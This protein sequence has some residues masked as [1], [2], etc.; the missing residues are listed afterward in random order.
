M[1][2]SII[3][4]PEIAG[5]LAL[6]LSSAAVGLGAEVVLP[7]LPVRVLLQTDAEEA[8]HTARLPLELPFGVGLV[9]VEF[10]VGY[11]TTEAVVPQQFLDALSL[12][13]EPPGT[14]T[15]V[16]LLNAE[17]RGEVWFPN[18]PGGF[19]FDRSILS[20]R[21][22]GFPADLGTEW[23]V[24]SAFAVTL[25][26]PLAWQNCEAGLWLDL[27]DNQDGGDSMAFLRDV[28]LVARAPFF[29]LESSTAPAGPYAAEMGVRHDEASRR[30]QLLRGGVARFFRL[31][32]DSP[33]SLQVL[34]RNSGAWQL[35]YEFPEPEPRLESAGRPTGPYVV[36]PLAVLDAAR[37]EF[38]L[39][40]NGPARFYRVRA[41]VRTALT[42]MT[43]RGGE[44]GITLAFEYRPQVFGLQS[45]AQPCGPFA[46]DPEA[47]FDTARQVITVSRTNFVRF[48]R[49]A[50]ST[51]GAGAREAVRF[52]GIRD[53]GRFWEL[54]YA[55]GSGAEPGK[56]EES[57]STKEEAR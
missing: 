55:V 41:Q 3:H 23:R 51:G 11:A 24:S 30:F 4:F 42:R 15:A 14:D 50:H 37:R 48:F 7:P 39:K 29:L 17:T 53:D 5:L 9:R 27:F 18:D 25:T 44:G 38:H 22:L 12:S 34:S 8:L 52:A 56:S 40:P 46:D 57:T 10:T 16:W 49:V 26:L 31:R 13:F 20:Q 1:P 21:P 6:G 33:V 19:D 54:P 2:R 32:A 36:E 45:S 43:V 47:Q 28:R 35:G